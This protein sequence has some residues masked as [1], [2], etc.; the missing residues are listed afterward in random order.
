MKRLM[1]SDAELRRCGIWGFYSKV[2]T[3]INLPNHIRYGQATFHWRGC[4][5]TGRVDG[6]AQALGSQ[7]PPGA[8]TYRRWTASLRSGRVET[9]HDASRRLH[10]KR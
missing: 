10:V 2:E 4:R 5:R 7:W 8:D 9:W 6:Y 1:L 3:Q